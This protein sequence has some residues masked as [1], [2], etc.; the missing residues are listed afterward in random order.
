MWKIAA[1]V[2]LKI[3]KSKYE[4]SESNFCER[5]YYS[6]SYTLKVQNWDRC[7]LILWKIGT[8]VLIKLW[9]SKF[10]TSVSN[11]CER[12]L[13]HYS[14][15]ISKSK[16][17]TNLSNCVKFLWNIPLQEYT[18][19]LGLSRPKAGRELW[20][21]YALKCEALKKLFES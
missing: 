14:L 2:L 17:E 6:T 20:N 5:Y 21:N 16:S 3:S 10:E 12:S 13:L 8:L 11:F 1:L 4:T 18:L 9:K 15:Q 19:I 7:V